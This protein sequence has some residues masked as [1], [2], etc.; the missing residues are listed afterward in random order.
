MRAR[1]DPRALLATGHSRRRTASPPPPESAFECLF[2][3]ALDVIL[4]I[5]P[6][7]GEI[8]RANRAI[9]RSLGYG[10]ARVAGRHFSIL[11]PVEVYSTPEELLAELRVHGPQ[12]G[13]QEFQRADG[14]VLRMDLTVTLIPWGAA[15]RMI[16]ATLRDASARHHTEEALRQSEERLQLVLSGADFA[17]WDWNLET[18]ASVFNAPAAAIAGY[19][20]NELAPQAQTWDALVHPN[21]RAH[22]L[23]VMNAHL[24]GETPSYEAEHR[25]RTKSGGW[26]WV[27]S[28]GRVVSRD[29]AGRPLRATGT[30]VD[31]SER[32]RG[33]EER[34]ILLEMA[35]EI[36][37]THEL[38]A[39]VASVERR[40]AQALPADVVGTVYWDTE[41]EAYRL[42][43]QHGL[44]A[45]L[46]TAARRMTFPLGAV[47][48]GRLA[49]GDTSAI[50][51]DGGGGQ[52]EKVGV[53]AWGEGAVRRSAADPRP[54]A[55][56]S[57]SPT[58]RAA[59]Q[60]PARSIFRSHRAPARRRDRD[61]GASPA[62]SRPRR[63]FLGDRP[64]QPGVDLVAG[65]AGVHDDLCRMTATVLDC[66]V[67]F[68]FLWSARWGPI[69]RWGAQAA[70]PRAARPYACCGSRSA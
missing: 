63:V 59:V 42:L 17:L 53:G 4:L 41:S 39:L 29:A 21:D 3:E 64:R 61:V 24:R 45:D 31:I 47:F 70:L 36:A 27:L 19:E 8:I 55:R 58:G 12:F 14:A 2:E 25:L 34:A 48:G 67:S 49:A 46:G 9:E 18:N 56:R 33:E 20:P 52:G 6:I 60:R 43:S 68:T 44:P 62:P 7:S 16:I 10:P 57:R 54:G 15:E 50:S 13:A 51:G 69:P 35:K 32:K 22:V 28:R 37:G 1:G 11:F 38:E 40:T 26:V 66:D 65:D 30:Q 23:A 5:D